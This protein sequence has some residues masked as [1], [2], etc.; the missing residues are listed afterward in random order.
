MN[1]MFCKGVRPLF[2]VSGFP[3]HIGLFK[4]VH[5]SFISCVCNCLNLQWM[6]ETSNKK[7]ESIPFDLLEQVFT[8]DNKKVEEAKNLMRAVLQECKPDTLLATRLFS[9]IEEK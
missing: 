7:E 1:V 4:D 3:E 2:V 6:P 5:I 9:F 8:I